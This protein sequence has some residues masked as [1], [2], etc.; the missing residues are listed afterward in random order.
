MIMRTTTRI[1][2]GL[3][4]AKSALI[5]IPLAAACDD[6]INASKMQQKAEGMRGSEGMKGEAGMS[7]SK[8]SLS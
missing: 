4:L 1:V 8:L 3:F 5:N 6:A 2:T 7:G